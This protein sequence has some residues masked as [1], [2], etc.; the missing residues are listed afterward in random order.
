MRLRVVLAGVALLPLLSACVVHVT[1]DGPQVLGRNEHVSIETTQLE[2]VHAARVADGRFY[3]RVDSNGC[4]DAG[5]FDVHVD[6]GD[7]GSVGLG[8]ERT[9]KDFCKA[10]VPDGVELSWTLEE[11]GVTARG[12]YR[13]LNPLKL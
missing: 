6:E 3:V 12:P 5:D 2:P 11:L 4:T 13:L 7:D 1:D 8:V 10:L 9:D